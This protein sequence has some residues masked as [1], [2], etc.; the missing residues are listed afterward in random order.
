[1]VS[2]IEKLLPEAK[3]V[4][5]TDIVS[6][7]E[8]QLKIEVS[9]KFLQNRLGK[10]LSYEDIKNTLSLLGISSEINGD[11]ITTIIPS[12]RA[13]GDLSLPE[14][15]L[16]EVGRILGYENF[17]Y[18]APKISLDSA[19]NQK[20]VELERNIREYLAKRCGLIEIFTYPWIHES[21]IDACGFDKNEWL[22]LEAP[23][24]PEQS[25]IKKSIIP[26]IVEACEKNTRYFNEFKIFELSQV[27]SKGEQSPNDEVEKLPIIERNLTCAFVSDKP[28]KIFR[29]AKGVIENIA[30]FTH[31][32]ALDLKQIEKPNWA[33][34]RIWLN[35]TKSN[36]VIG[37]IGLLSVK[38]LKESGIKHHYIAIIDLNV[39]KL[40][41][42][43]S[44]T[45][46][47]T[48]LPEFPLVEKDLSVL[49]DETINWKDIEKTVKPKVKD[50]K[51]IDE[52]KGKQIEKGK[53]S[54][55]F[56]VFLESK[57][58]TMT[59][60]Q[61]DEKLREILNKINKNF[62]GGLR[63]E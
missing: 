16:E 43:P 27:F 26:S 34:P 18:I 9:H 48:H 5:F 7:K 8:E 25:H 60:E 57:E 61:I 22:E 13:T 51:F 23:P 47:F 19:I 52:Y 63:T 49:L 62:G 46:K 17:D 33:D 53:K 37:S 3:L 14:D 24:S 39:E 30:R 6:K 42:L 50:V 12:W 59:T 4:G 56:R 36:N 38:A 58:G 32:K 55:T 28:E 44:R 54:L 21:F 45:N 41:F 29:E 15:I 40:E 35:I 2:L 10:S 1:M 31:M 11:T 20:G